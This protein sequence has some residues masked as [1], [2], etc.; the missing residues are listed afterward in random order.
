MK[1]KRYVDFVTENRKKSN[2]RIWNPS[3]DKINKGSISMRFTAHVGPDTV[4][5]PNLANSFF[6]IAANSP[7]CPIEDNSQIIHNENIVETFIHFNKKK[8]PEKY[9]HWALNCREF[10]GAVQING[11]YGLLYHN[12]K[13]DLKTLDTLENLITVK[14]PE[15]KEDE[16]IFPH[17]VWSDEQSVM[18]NLKE[19]VNI[20]YDVT[21]QLEIYHNM[22]EHGIIHFDLNPGNVFLVGKHGHRRGLLNDFGISREKNKPLEKLFN[23]ASAENTRGNYYSKDGIIAN[24]V[25]SPPDLDQH[26]HSQP[27]IDSYCTSNLLCLMLTG[28]LVE[29]FYKEENISNEDR[30]FANNKSYNDEQNKE[31]KEELEE[32]LT[33][34]KENI[35]LSAYE[36]YGGHLEMEGYS[37]ELISKLVDIIS[38]GTHINREKR[39]QTSNILNE[40]LKTIDDAFNLGINRGAYDP[41]IDNLSFNS[42][43]DSNGDYVVLSDSDFEIDINM[44]DY[45]WSYLDDTYLKD[46]LLLD[47]LEIA[48]LDLNTTDCDL[49]PIIEDCEKT[50]PLIDEPD[51]SK[52]EEYNEK[53]TKNELKKN[54]LFSDVMSSVGAYVKKSLPFVGLG[55]LG[56]TLFGGINLIENKLDD[57]DFNEIKEQYQELKE[58]T[59]GKFIDLKKYLFQSNESNDGIK[60]NANLNPVCGSIYVKEDFQLPEEWVD[61]ECQIIDEDGIKDSGCFELKEYSTLELV[62]EYNLGLCPEKY[63]CC[64]SKKKEEI[65]VLENNGSITINKK[66]ELTGESSEE[67]DEDHFIN[68]NNVLT[69]NGK[70]PLNDGDYCWAGPKDMLESWDQCHIKYVVEKGG[71]VVS[72]DGLVLPE[73]KV[74]ITRLKATLGSNYDFNFKLNCSSKPKSY[75]SENMDAESLKFSIS[76][77]W[78]KMKSSNGL[79]NTIIQMGNY[80]SYF[81]PEV[82][83]FPGGKVVLELEGL[84]FSSQQFSYSEKDSK[85]KVYEEVEP[86]FQ[87]DLNDLGSLEVKESDNLESIKDDNQ[88]LVLPLD[89]PLVKQVEMFART[90]EEH[91]YEET[92]QVGTLNGLN[93]EEPGIYYLTVPLSS[94]ARKKLAIS[95]EESYASTSFDNVLVHNYTDNSVID[96]NLRAIYNIPSLGWDGFK[97]LQLESEQNLELSCLSNDLNV[98]IVSGYVSYCHLKNNSNNYNNNC[99]FV[100]SDFGDFKIVQIPNQNNNLNPFENQNFLDKISSSSVENLDVGVVCYDP[101]GDEPTGVSNVLSFKIER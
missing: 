38:T 45:S 3:S 51:F 10:K 47:K 66:D 61:Y 40:E 57:N 53:S 41:E 76:T 9:D 11:T 24:S 88:E 42:N 60:P 21:E 77:N 62:E 79:I 65:S 33:R 39:Y 1:N 85:K 27:S 4:E 52:S 20:S 13:N 5:D 14:A 23:N 91:N 67:N 7:L 68:L 22:G 81:E 43:K 34:I 97:R 80:D 55:A 89:D 95:N 101:V 72:Y 12:L 19:I 54:Y 92:Y 44:G 49:F 82:N 46:L 70:F 93:D 17:E 18:L 74:D 100:S 86:N 96:H 94:E 59:K 2:V 75:H 98:H 71:D 69:C 28:R 35:S 73:N 50:D 99:L 87:D 64:P 6:K 26:N 37:E 36:K 48:N 31:K 16:K 58:G 15:K 78:I 25:Y 8:F 29:Y 90:L 63:L 56:L 32:R 83:P 84:N 30:L